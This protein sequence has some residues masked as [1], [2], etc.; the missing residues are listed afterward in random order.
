MKIVF[1][2]EDLEEIQHIREYSDG[3]S[4]P[5]EIGM[6]EYQG[7]FNY[8]GIYSR[9][10]RVHLNGLFISQFQVQHENAFTQHIESDF[11]YLQMHFEITT[12]GCVYRPNARFEPDTNIMTGRHSLLF[13]PALK[14]HLT[15][16][17]TPFASSVEIELSLDFLRRLFNHDLEQLGIFGTHIEKNVPALLGNGSYP[18][19]PRMKEILAELRECPFTGIL[20]R[21]FLEAKVCELLTL[22]I[23]QIT[24][25]KTAPSTLKK[26]DVDKLYEVRELLSQNLTTPYSIEQLSRLVGLNRTK[27]QEGFKELYQ[28]TVFGYLTDCRM[29]QA[30]ELIRKGQF[31]TI[32]EVSNLIGYKNHQHF[33][34]AFKKKFGYLPRELKGSVRFP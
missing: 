14:G 19:T 15:Y 3:Y 18:I 17:K 2:S 22:Q 16:L 20:K 1:K 34:V 24:T 8:A 31:E 29:E 12:G 32:A 6:T 21:I 27:L 25:A 13:Y 23:D 28:T 26:T 33:T 11:P 7:E 5:N 10:H 9:S 4:V 30:K